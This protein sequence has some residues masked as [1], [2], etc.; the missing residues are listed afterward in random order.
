[1]KITYYGHSCF[2]VSVSGKNLLFDPFVSGNQLAR[3]IDV[4]RIPADYIL[5][6]HGH[7]DHIADA[8]AIGQRTRAKAISNFEIVEWLARQGLQDGHPMNHGGAWSFDF[9]RIQYVNA[10]HSSSLPDGSYGG[11]PG[12]FVVETKEGSFYYAGDTALT[13]DMKVIGEKTALAFAVLPIG[14]NFTMGVDDAIRAADW[15]GARQV[16]GVHYD[17]F[18]PIRIDRELAIKKFAAAGKTLHLIPIGG[19]LQL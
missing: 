12:G 6:S 8:V 2:G 18:P 5:V 16:V 15:V 10:I 13:M 11:N 1:M 14:D 19:A 9:G 17:T 7:S 4:G 3:A